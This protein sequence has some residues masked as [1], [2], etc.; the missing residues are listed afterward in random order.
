M[1]AIKFG[2]FLTQQEL[3]TKEVAYSYLINSRENNAM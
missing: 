2:N 3:I 1:S